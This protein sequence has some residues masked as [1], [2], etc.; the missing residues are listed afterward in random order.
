MD[1]EVGITRRQEPQDGAIAE[2]GV[3]GPFMQMTAS[4]LQADISV[5]FVVQPAEDEMHAQCWHGIEASSALAIHPRMG[6]C[7]LGKAAIQKKV[8]ASKNV[9]IDPRIRYSSLM[10][11]EGIVSALVAPMLLADQV[12]GVLVAAWKSER[13]QS[14][15]QRGQIASIANAASLVLVQMRQADVGQRT[16]GG[17]LQIHGLAVALRSQLVE[18]VQR[19][20]L[21]AGDPCADLDGSAGTVLTQIP[22]DVRAVKGIA[23]TAPFLGLSPRNPHRLLAVRSRSENIPSAVL[24]DYLRRT[25]PRNSVVCEEREGPVIF[26]TVKTGAEE[27]VDDLCRDVASSV[28]DSAKRGLGADLFIGISSNCV[29]T[30]D[31]GKRHREAS[32]AVEALQDSPLFRDKNGV[33]TFGELGTYGLLFADSSKES[34][35]EFAIN[36]LGPILDYDAIRTTSLTKTL[37]IFL[38]RHGNLQRTAADLFLHVSSLRYRLDRIAEMCRVNLADPDDRFKLQLAIKI[39]NFYGLKGRAVPTSK[40]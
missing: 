1:R 17:T 14:E 35:I 24:A 11:H 21:E 18:W 33:L 23:Q 7:L 36:L 28:V 13:S 34:L 15:K 26:L 3:L 25:A 39:V 5:L 8:L 37:D 16:V 30:E 12:L 27:G 40:R 22:N 2:R 4:V 20:D 29:R 19:L 32:R 6:E 10:E 31:V 38:Q 9:Q